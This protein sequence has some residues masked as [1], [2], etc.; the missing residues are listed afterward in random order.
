HALPQPLWGRTEY[1]VHDSLEQ[2][3]THAHV[4]E[5]HWYRLYGYATPIE[6][7]AVHPERVVRVVRPVLFGQLIDLDGDGYPDY[8]RRDCDIGN[9]TCVWFG[10]G[11]EDGQ[12]FFRPAPDFHLALSPEVRNGP[13]KLD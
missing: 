1:A 8:V 9:E 10:T 5:A 3:S 4:D 6:G 2:E 7:G 11:N 13:Q 12:G